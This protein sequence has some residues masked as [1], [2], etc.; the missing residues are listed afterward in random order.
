MTDTPPSAKCACIGVFGAPNAGKS[1][2]VNRLAGEKIAVTSPKPQT[3]RRRV[4]G[5]V[6]EGDTQLVFTD[7]PGI[8]R[9][10]KQK[11]LEAYIVNNALE[12]ASGNDANLL[13]IDAKK[14]FD[15]TAR[16]AARVPAETNA[17]LYIVLNKIDALKDKTVLLAL[18][19]EISAALPCKEVFMVSAKKGKGTEAILSALREAAPPGPFLFD[20][21]VISDAPLAFDLAEIT[22][23]SL[24]R[25]LRDELPYGVSVLTDSI[26]ETDNGLEAHQTVY[27]LRRAHKGIILGKDGA[28]IKRVGEESRKRCAARAGAP[29]HLY[30]HVKVKEDWQ[31]A[32]ERYGS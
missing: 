22:R 25:L 28:M 11:P 3:T 6:T 19:A 12:A 26:E 18:A 14:G 20:E 29:V 30:L 7:T 5:V 31:H 13:V 27:T 8:F 32:P 24:F 23:E 21:E 17:P 16:Y 1:T 4:R 15:D 9:P 2:L 10:G